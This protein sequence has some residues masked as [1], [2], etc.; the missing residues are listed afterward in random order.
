MPIESKPLNTALFLFAHQDDEF[1]IF[2]R[3]LDELEAGNQVCCAYLTSGGHHRDHAIAE[4][5]NHESRAVLVKMGVSDNNIFF[6]GCSLKISDGMLLEHLDLASNWIQSWW[7][8][9]PRIRSVYIPAWEGG[10]PDHDALHAITLSVAHEKNM[11]SLVR[12]FALYNGYHC[13]GPLFRVLLPLQSNGPIDSRYISWK[14][15]FRFLLHCLSYSSQKRT[16]F[17]LFPFVLAHYIFYGLQSTQPVNFERIRSRPHA[18]SL[19]Y[20]RRGFCTWEN[21]ARRMAAWNKS[22]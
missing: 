19:Y 14:N 1:G 21:M 10:H 2:Q 8:N 15:R 11:L 7:S 22:I 9:Y 18:G 17:G 3:I 20:E 13:S 12:Q 6:A 4:R 16:W 5:R